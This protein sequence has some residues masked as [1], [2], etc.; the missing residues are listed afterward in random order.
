MFSTPIA[1]SLLLLQAQSAKSGNQHHAKASGSSI[2]PL[3]YRRHIDWKWTRNEWNAD[4]HP[5]QTTRRHLEE[6]VHTRV[7]SIARNELAAEAEKYAKVWRKHHDDIASL[8]G[9]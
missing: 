6:I 1:L 4:E 7:P 9:F 3:D 8:Y 5:F 2:K